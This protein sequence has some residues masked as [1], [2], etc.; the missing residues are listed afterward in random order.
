MSNNKI[1]CTE[2]IPDFVETM[3]KPHGKIV[4]CK[5]TNHETILNNMDKT[6]ALLVRGGI[7]T[8]EIIE[9]STDL[10]VVGRSGVGCESVDVKAASK[11]KIPVVNTPLAGSRAVAEG[12]ITMMLALTKKIFYWDEQLKSGNWDSRYFTKAGDLD[13]AT[14]G[15]IGFGSI[16]RILAQ[17]VAPFNMEILVYDP[18]V[19][20]N[21]LNEPTVRFVDLDSLFKQ[22]D[23]ISIHANLT[24]ETRG[25]INKNKLEIIKP[26][27]II[28]NLARGGMIENLDVL[29]DALKDH[30]LSG[31][32]LDTFE[33]EPPDVSH[34]IFKLSNC[35][36]SPH[37]I[38]LTEQ[39]TY[40]IF[41]SLAE[42]VIAILNGNRPRYVVNPEVLN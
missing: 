12:A 13:G 6:T 40:N 2:P 25:I 9:A 8:E 19:D 21:Q 20:E 22:S 31:V 38:A 17:L 10:K 7:I 4:V 11:Q 41:K 33:P 29:Y 30:R 37:S 39:A 26:G 35:I 42:D 36:T 15:I 27:A 14:L 28:I 34:P 24:D 5:N 18:F 1:L 23:F 16:G 3:L 32:G